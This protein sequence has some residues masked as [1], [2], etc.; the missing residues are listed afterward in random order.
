MTRVFIN[1]FFVP[2]LMILAGRGLA[3]TFTTLHS[4]ASADGVYPSAGLILSG[5]IL[6]GTA[7]IRPL[8]S[9]L[10]SGN[11]MYGTA[12]LG[13]GSLNNGDGTV[14]AINTDGTGFTDLLNLDD[15]IGDGPRG[16]LV[17]EDNI[18]YGATP[19]G[20]GYN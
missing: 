14:F 20:G 15:S 13:G 6:Y 10:L 1:L 16:G 12:A 17:L 2:M 5:N 3:Q 8:C 18:L 9:L 11:T 19:H 7:G 4:F